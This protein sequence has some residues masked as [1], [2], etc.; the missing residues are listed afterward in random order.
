M[1]LELPDL[2]SSAFLGAAAGLGGGS[3]D[4]ATTLLGMNQLLGGGLDAEARD[5][6]LPSDFADEARAKL[7][8]SQA[9]ALRPG[10]I[11]KGGVRKP[12][13]L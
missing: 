8:K 5:K 7:H 6:I 1:T 12:G 3:S 13:S 4:A 2:D 9:I 10:Q 11:R